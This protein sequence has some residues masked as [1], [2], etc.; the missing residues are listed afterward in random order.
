MNSNM[1]AEVNQVGRGLES[2]GWGEDYPG[3]FVTWWAQSHTY[4]ASLEMEEAMEMM[5]DN[6]TLVVEL[7]AE[8]WGGELYVGRGGQSRSD[9]IEK[10]HVLHDEHKTWFEA[11]QVSEVI[12]IIFC[13]WVII[14]LIKLE[15]ALALD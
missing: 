2:P 7:T 15:D 5:E 12:I 8:T 4:K 10:M 9:M 13:W 1:G 3:S 11:E 14:K 6:D